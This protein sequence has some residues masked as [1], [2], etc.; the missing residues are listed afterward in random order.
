MRHGGVGFVFPDAS[1]FTNPSQRGHTKGAALQL[2]YNHLNNQGFQSLTPSFVWGSGNFGLGGFASRLGTKLD[3][4]EQSVDSI[5]GEIGVSLAN[6]RLGIG[7]NYIRSIDTAQ[8]SDGTMT[9]AMRVSGQRSHGMNFTV[10]GSTTVNRAT[11]DIKTGTVG[12]GYGFATG[13]FEASYSVTDFQDPGKNNEALGA[14]HLEG[15]TVY[16]GAG[17]GYTKP[18]NAALLKGRFGVKYKKVDFSVHADHLFLT[19]R[20]IAYGGTFRVTF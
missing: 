4:S 11:R 19:G 3:A 10:A 8:N 20:D 9:A 15:K 1:N 12:L 2:D 18:V 17:Y 7:V 16:F 14:L 13:G 5:G 6:D